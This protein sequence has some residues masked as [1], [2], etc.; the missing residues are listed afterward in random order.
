MR[1]QYQI[2]VEVASG[3][4]SVLPGYLADQTQARKLCVD[5]FHRSVGEPI[6][7]IAIMRKGN[8]VDCYDGQWATQRETV[9]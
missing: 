1:N 6:R 7:T 9:L 4:V 5:L 2:S 8:V 3:A